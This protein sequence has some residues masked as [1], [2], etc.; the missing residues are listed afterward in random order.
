MSLID[1]EISA[2]I[3]NKKNARE[4]KLENYRGNKKGMAGRSE[5]GPN[6]HQEL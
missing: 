5:Q 3:Q 4:K 6:M 1:E 2:E